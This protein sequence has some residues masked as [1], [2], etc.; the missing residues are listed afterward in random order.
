MAMT[1]CG[2]SKAQTTATTAGTPAQT[3]ATTA[4]SVVQPSTV[5]ACLQRAGYNVST[6]VAQAV[7][8]GAALTMNTDLDSGFVARGSARE[9]WGYS[10]PSE[11]GE[12]TA[13]GASGGQG[14]A[15]VVLFAHSKGA[16]EAAAEVQTAS[17]QKEGSG[18]EATPASEGV[19][20]AWRDNAAWIAWTNGANTSEQIASC[21][22]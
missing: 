11:K 2:S 6:A 13:V 16:E 20:V 22:P 8:N 15:T 17:E 14:E 5:E 10:H 7:S 18:S 9:P 21:L 19:K 1:G 12:L 4:A 3:T